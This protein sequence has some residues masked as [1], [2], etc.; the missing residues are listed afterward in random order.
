MSTEI[1][2]I[3]ELKHHVEIQGALSIYLWEALYFGIDQIKDQSF[4]T[5]AL[6]T[7][8]FC[9]QIASLGTSLEIQNI[10]PTSKP[11]SQM[12]LASLIDLQLILPLKETLQGFVSQ[13][14]T[15]LLW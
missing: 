3:M 2:K 6:P 15:S 1:A 12:S 5:F 10:Q 14:L 9:F 13:A 7:P 4:Y 11:R 8:F